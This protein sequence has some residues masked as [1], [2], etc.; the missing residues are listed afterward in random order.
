MIRP[1][2]LVSESATG[3]E[4]LTE[5]VTVAGSIPRAGVAMLTVRC[6]NSDKTSNKVFSAIDLSMQRTKKAVDVFE[7]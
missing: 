5:D 2:G 3:Q 1:G 7:L 6:L 4:V